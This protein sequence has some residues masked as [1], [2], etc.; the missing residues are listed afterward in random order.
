ML[1]NKKIAKPVKRDPEGVQRDILITAT[2]EFAKNGLSGARIDDIAALT[3]T[4]KRMIYYY[5]GDKEGLYQACLERSYERVRAGE[6][7]LDLDGLSP[8]QALATLVA[9]TF[10]H[11]RHNPDFIRLVMIENIHTANFLKRS[12]SIPTANAA[13]IDTLAGILRAGQATGDFRSDIDP[14]ELHWQ[15][16]ALSFFN[17]SNSSTFSALFGSALFEDERQETL[18]E[19]VVEM[20][21]RYVCHSEGMPS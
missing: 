13:A 9:F 17:V 6:Q 19:H 4:S 16:S 12:Q 21:M 20:I 14:M 7:S 11:H 3:K 1:P 5:F 18:N 10:D 15:I 2:A 8:R